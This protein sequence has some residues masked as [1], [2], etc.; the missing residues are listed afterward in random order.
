MMTK[1]FGSKLLYILKFNN[2]YCKYPIYSS[3]DYLDFR[4]NQTVHM[5]LGAYQQRT[6][7]VS[8]RNKMN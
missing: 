2:I 5:T 3:F 4:V 6:V 1:A 7:P 8:S